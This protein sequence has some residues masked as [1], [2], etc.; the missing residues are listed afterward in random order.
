MR[1]PRAKSAVGVVVC[2][3]TRY[4]GCEIVQSAN[5]SLLTFIKHCDIGCALTLVCTTKGGIELVP[6][7]RALGPHAQLPD[8]LEAPLER[9]KHGTPPYAS[10]VSHSSW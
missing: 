3:T 9:C 4:L 10:F 6:G 2:S 1:A 8:V 7:P 5:D